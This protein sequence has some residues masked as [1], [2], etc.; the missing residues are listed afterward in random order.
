MYGFAN[1]HVCMKTADVQR[2]SRRIHVPVFTAL[3]SEK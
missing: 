2:W 1:V 3:S